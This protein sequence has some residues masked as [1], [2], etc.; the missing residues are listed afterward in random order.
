M[1]EELYS[2]CYRLPDQGLKSWVGSSIKWADSVVK[3]KEINFITC[4]SNET[5][6][7]SGLMEILH[8]FFLGGGGNML[9]SPTLEFVW[10]RAVNCFSY[11]SVFGSSILGIYI[12]STVV[13]THKYC[14]QIW[15]HLVKCKTFVS[16]CFSHHVSELSSSSGSSKHDKHVKYQLNVKIWKQ[17]SPQNKQTNHFW[18]QHQHPFLTHLHDKKMES[19][20]GVNK[21]LPSHIT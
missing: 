2:A 11:I 7:F 19:R 17:I 12:Q 1:L 8:F 5:M 20:W 15:R 10:A 14:I 3:Y 9:W 21:C 13:W 6:L 4:I 18:S 16:Q